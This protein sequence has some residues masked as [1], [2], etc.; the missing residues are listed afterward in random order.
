VSGFAPELRGEAALPDAAKNLDR[1]FSVFSLDLLCI[2][3][4]DGYFKR[5]SP[6]WQTTFGYTDEE[7][8]ARPILDFVHESDRA[9]TRA[10]MAK[11]ASE[12]ATLRFTNRYLCKDGSYQWLEW[13]AVAY[14]EEQ[15]IYAAAR[16]I[17]DRL[18]IEQLKN[19]LSVRDAHQ[20]G[21]VET[22]S[23]ILHD[24][25]NALTGIGARAVAA[26]STIERVTVSDKLL[27]SAAFLQMHAAAMATALGEPRARALVDLMT[28]MAETQVRARDEALE[29][30]VKLLAFLSHAQE[31]ITTHRA[32]SRAGSGPSRE[33]MNLRKLLFDAQ[34]M[35]SD[36][37]AKRGGVILIQCD[38]GLPNVLVE[39]SKLMGVLINLIKNAVEAFDTEPHATS[40]EI[41]LVAESSEHGVRVEVRDNGSGFDAAKAARLFT[42]GYSTKSRGSGVGLNA[43][44]LVIESMGGILELESD[45][46]GKGAVARIT[47]LQEALVK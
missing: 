6:L 15:L 18:K 44:R 1:F 26:Q 12:G 23:S 22:A 35:M 4:M 31:L 5:L 9:A 43:S 33:A 37:M 36:A 28:T 32:Y 10:E 45:G 40:P 13:T 11:I 34:L 46:P 17:S 8:C 29:S 14:G 19:A 7:F 20:Q 47:F 27:K 41:T 30:L 42:Y 16:D 39:R 3:G 24:L 2:F 21:R 38:P 25:G